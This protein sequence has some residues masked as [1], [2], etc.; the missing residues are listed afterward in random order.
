MNYATVDDLIELWRSLTE[1]EAEQA[2]ELIGLVSAELRVKARQLGRNLDELIAEDSDLE[3]VAKSVVCDV[4]RRYMNSN[5]DDS[6]AT[7]Q[8][9]QS[10]GGYSTSGTYLSPGGGLFIKKSEL[11]RLGLR[12]QRY[13]VI[14]F[15]D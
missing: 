1:D 14:E 3:D 9:S 6:P 13:G 11:A 10:V 8:F 7:T 4:V 5:A 15:Y 2:G 12:R